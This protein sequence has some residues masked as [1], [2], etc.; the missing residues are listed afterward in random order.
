MKNVLVVLQAPA[1][2]ASKTLMVTTDLDKAKKR[3]QAEKDSYS[4]VK[5]EIVWEKRQYEDELQFYEG[6]HGE[7]LIQ[8]WEVNE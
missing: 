7:Y 1:Y 4:R 6:D 8:E 2:D 5:Q 3:C